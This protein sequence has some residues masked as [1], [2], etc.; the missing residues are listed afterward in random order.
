MEAQ[1]SWFGP[2]GSGLKIQSS[3]LREQGSGF[4]I[5]DRCSEFTVRNSEFKA[6][7]KT[8]SWRL[9]IHGLEFRA[10]ATKPRI[11]GSGFEIRVRAQSSEFT[12]R[13]LGLKARGSKLRVLSSAFTVRRSEFRKLQKVNSG[14]ISNADFVAPEWVSDAALKGKEFF[15][16]HFEATQPNSCL[17]Q[18]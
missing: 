3:R 11:R 15:Y 16:E 1:K 17:S 7:G 14:P 10:R 6:R 5:R 8:Q 13:S 9:R 4:R 18:N 2:Q 12:V